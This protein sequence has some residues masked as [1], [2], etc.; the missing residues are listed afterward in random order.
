MRI[1][2][3]TDKGKKR[4]INEDSF[5]VHILD[6]KKAAFGA[7]CDG[8]GGANGGEVASRIAIDLI[9]EKIQLLDNYSRKSQWNKLILD[10][11]ESSNRAIFEK[12]IEDTSLLGM[13]TTFVGAFCGE[14][15]AII[16]NVG[17]SRAYLIDSDSIKQISKD[18]SLVNELVEKGELS[19]VQATNHPNK[20]VITRALGVDKTVKCDVFDIKVAKGQYLLLCSDGLTEEVSEP[21]IHFQVMTCNTGE[22]KCRSLIDIANSRGGHDNITVVIVEF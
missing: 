6:D 13:G 10:F 5:F 2:G 9:Q 21:E 16:A 11:V 12:S 19:R 17:D 3:L 14:N 1:Y 15:K 22:E 18:H 4:I 7:V 8:M 20:N